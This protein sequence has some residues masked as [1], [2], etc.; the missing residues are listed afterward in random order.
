MISKKIFT[1][2]TKNNV[3]DEAMTTIKLKFVFHQS[4]SLAILL[5]LLLR[6]PGLWMVEAVD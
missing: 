6:V 2:R 1:I 4:N 3:I 5:C